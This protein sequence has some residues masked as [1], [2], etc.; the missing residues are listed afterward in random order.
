LALVL[1][2]AAF[3]ADFAVGFTGALGPCFTFD[4]GLGEAFV[5]AL[6]TGLGLAGAGAFLAGV[7]ATA[8]FDAGDGLT[9]LAA[10]GATTFFV[11][12]ADLGVDLTEGLVTGLAAT[13]GF[14]F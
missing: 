4:A 7:F 14:D 5:I 3:T 12:V 13:L 8:F 9:T 6:A 1:L 11:C 2:G 10:L